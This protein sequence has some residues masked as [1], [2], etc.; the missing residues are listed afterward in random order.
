MGIFPKVDGGLPVPLVKVVAKQLLLALDFLHRECHV[1]HTDLKPDNILVELD[2]V[3]A[4]I[5][6]QEETRPTTPTQVLSKLNVKLT[7]FGTAV[8]KLIPS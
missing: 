3:D 4:A 2:N 1:V 6:I 8:Y 7:D 5:E